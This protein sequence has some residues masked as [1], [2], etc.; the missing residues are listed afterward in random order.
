MT[1]STY[2]VTGV[3]SGIGA[4]L[5]RL[6]KA[7]NHRVIGFDIQETHDNVDQFIML[8][9]NDVSSIALAAASI[10]EP[11]NGLCNNAGLPPRAGLEEAILQVNFLGTRAFTHAMTPHFRTGASIVNMAS[12]AGHGWRDGADQV[13]RL[14]AIT[15][16]HQLAEFIASEGIDA[17]RCYNL[18]KEAMIL[19]TV[20]E[21]EAMVRCGVRINSLSPGGIST[22]ILGDFQK[23]F[24]AQMAKNLVRAGRPGAPTEIA[25]IAAFLLSP[26]SNWIKGADIAIDG[27]MSAFNQSDAMDL[28]CLSLGYEPQ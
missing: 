19:W 6:L 17:T 1:S 11:L 25:E 22:G 4:E 13:K 16:K 27:G 5:A 18:T 9:L 12:R 10:D 21:T 20:A 28:S 23:A 26:A 14:S 8:D 15:D 7:Q 24:G 3:A 2:A